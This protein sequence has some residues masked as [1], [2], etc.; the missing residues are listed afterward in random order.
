MD[1]YGSLWMNIPLWINVNIMRR[2]FGTI[3]SLVG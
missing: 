2:G 1:H 3:S